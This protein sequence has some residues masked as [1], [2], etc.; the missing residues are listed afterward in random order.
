MCSILERAH[1]GTKPDSFPGTPITEKCSDCLRSL[2]TTGRP[3]TGLPTSSTD[4]D[5]FMDILILLWIVLLWT[6]FPALPDPSGVSAVRSGVFSK[7]YCFDP[8]GKYPRFLS[9]SCC[10]CRLC[11]HFGPAILVF[12]HCSSNSILESLI[13]PVNHLHFRQT[14]L[15]YVIRPP[16]VPHTTLLPSGPCSD[17][18]GFCGFHHLTSSHPSGQP[19]SSGPYFDSTDLS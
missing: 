15:L 6:T 16:P 3:Y 1:S 18:S 4:L 8:L 9:K 13:P 12:G 7:L 14:R 10:C 5:P 17:S 19:H 11:Y 2:R